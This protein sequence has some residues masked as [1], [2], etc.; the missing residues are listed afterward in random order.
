MRKLSVFILMT[1]FWLAATDIYIPCCAAVDTAVIAEVNGDIIY[2]VSLQ[3][4]IKAI[5]RN[6]PQIRPEEGAGS[7]KILNI[8]EQMIDERLI[9]QDAYMVELDKSA[10]FIK[11]IESFVITQSII[12]LR[13]E[14]V[15][16]K[17]NI[18]DQDILD[19]FKERYEKDKPAP[20]GMFK[21]VEARIRKNIRKEQE[22]ELSDNFISDLRKQADIWIDSD[23]IELL[24]PEKNYTGG[25]SVVASVNG[26][27]IPLDNFLHDMKQSAQK[28]HMKRPL[29]K[30]NE[31]PEK[32]QLEL[33]EKILNNLIAFKLIEQEALNRNYV[34]EPVFMDMIKKRKELILINEFKAKLIYPLVIPTEN[35]LTQYYKEHINNFKK[36]YEVWFREMIFN[37]RKDADNALKELKQG[38]SF[39]FLGP[40]VSERWKP[41]QRV[42]WVNANSFSPAIR[43]E[44]NRLKPGEISEVIADNRQYKIIKLKG[45]RGGGYIEFSRLVNTLRKIVGQNNFD[46]VLSKYL[47]K[48]RK[49][50]RIKINKKVLRQI[51]EKYRITVHSEDAEAAR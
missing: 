34:N 40:L 29:S 16:D 17:I 23:L 1:L 6:K 2:E 30:N 33:K 25:K 43:K 48:L 9:I 4:R 42:V 28:Q 49:G 26:D 24:D 12:R 41:R 50:S 51:E 27:M 44:L 45:K 39:E 14:V 20:E 5:H 36:D 3:E 37:T 15:L 8:V 47:A 21:K 31:Y 13:K 46:K 7:I 18:S 19:Y 10:D 22:K 11:S 35:E 38:A 32:M